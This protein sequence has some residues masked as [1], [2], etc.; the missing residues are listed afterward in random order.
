MG[1]IFPSRMQKNVVKNSNC[2]KLRIVNITLLDFQFQFIFTQVGDEY[3]LGRFDIIL[4]Y[5]EVK[6]N[7]KNVNS[8]FQ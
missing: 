3:E 1:L 7:F 2:Q 6:C 4:I 8:A 5:K